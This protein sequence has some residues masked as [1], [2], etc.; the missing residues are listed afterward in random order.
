[1]SS[2]DTPLISYSYCV[3]G[4]TFVVVSVNVT[5]APS[6]TSFVLAVNAY[7]G[8]GVSEVSFTFT[9]YVSPAIVIFSVS[10]PSLFASSIS[11]TG[12]SARPFASIVTV[13]VSLPP[14]MSAADTP[15][16]SYSYCVPGATFV[17]LN[18][19]TTS[20]PSS[21]AS[22]L[23]L[24]SNVGT[25]VSEVSFTVTSYVCPAIVIFS[26]STPSLF[27]SANSDTG[28]VA[29]PL[30]SIVTVP[31]SLPPSRSAEDTPLITYSYC[32]PGAT[33]VVV[34]VNTTSAP[35]S[36]SS[37]LAVSLNVGCGSA[38]AGCGASLPPS[39]SSS[40][41]IAMPPPTTAAPPNTH[42]AV[43]ELAPAAALLAA[44]APDAPAI[45]APAAPPSEDTAPF[46]C[47]R[48][49]VSPLAHSAPAS[50][51]AGVI[52]ATSPPGN[53]TDTASSP[54]AA[55]SKKPSTCTTSPS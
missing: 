50:S 43:E 22:A 13:P 30:A 19:N 26:V 16:I 45:E 51:L 54:S 6:S 24:S 10:S 18:V 39:S 9:S 49:N 1:M 31:V 8:T 23:E 47:A 41:A 55:M 48:A 4:A 37:A 32:V 11:D 14:T 20:A 40:F 3:P 21:T 15:L 46:V 38:G 25:G 34:N 2:A 27:R 36:T 17:V 33:F 29:L 7:V 44:E 53:A 28:I 42:Q 35:S 12:I 52:C 5:S